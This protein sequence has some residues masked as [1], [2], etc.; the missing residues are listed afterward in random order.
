[1]FTVGEGKSSSCVGIFRFSCF[2]TMT[3][4]TPKSIL[5]GVLV[6]LI[7]ATRETPIPAYFF[8]TAIGAIS[9]EKIDAILSLMEF[10]SRMK[11]YYDIYYLANRFDFDGA[12]LT[13]A[14]KKTF[15]NRGFAT[16]IGAISLISKLIKLFPVDIPMISSNT[17]FNSLGVFGTF[18][19]RKSTSTVTRLSKLVTE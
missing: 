13:K 14:L 8:A 19:R 3:S 1:M 12:T 5:N 10:S 9:L 6:F 15:K 2:G 16:A 17:G 7:L 18:R 11:D 4:P